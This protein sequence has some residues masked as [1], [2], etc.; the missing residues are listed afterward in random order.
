MNL[1]KKVFVASSLALAFSMNLFGDEVYTIKDKTLKEALEII[2]KKSNLSYIANDKL[3]ETRKINNIENIEGTQKALDKLLQGTGLKAIIKNEAIVI[4]KSEA[5]NSSKNGNDLGKIDVVA[6]SE[7]TEGTG[8]YTLGSTS[9]ATNLSMSLKETPQSISVI[10]RQRIDDQSLN[11]ITDVLQQMPGISVQSIGNGRSTIYSRGGYAITNYQLDGIPTYTNSR[12]QNASQGLADMAVYDHIE[13][14]RGATGLMTGAGDPSGTINMIRK[15]PTKDTQASME[16]TVGSWDL[17]RAQLDISGSLNKNGTIRGRVVSAYQ[18]NESKKDYFEEEKKIFYGVVEADITDTTLLSVGVDYQEYKPTGSSSTG[19]PLFY[20]DGSQTNFSRSLNPGAKWSYDN[21]ETYNIFATLQQELINDWRLKVSTNYLHTDREFY[22]AT[23]A[24]GLLDKNTGDGIALYGGA[25]DAE[26]TQKGFDINIDGTYKL[27][28]RE[29]ELVLGY[30]YFKYDNTHSPLSGTNVEGNPINYYNWGNNPSKPDTKNGKLYDWDHVIIQ[31][32]TYLATRFHPSDDLSLILGGRFSDYEYDDKWDYPV[33]S[34]SNSKENYDETAFTP[35]AGI[36][37]DINEEHSIYISY[38]SVF[39]PQNSKDKNGSTLDPREGNNYEIGYK[40][41]LFGGALNSSIAVYRIEQDNLAV[42][43]T[44]NYI[45]GTTDA[46]YKAIDG[47]VTK[48]LDLEIT[49]EINSNWNLQASYT[50]SKTE[51]QNNERIKTTYPRHMVKLWTTYNLDKLT[52]GGG[53][54]WQSKI[55]FD[56]T[57]WQ[58]PNM[59]FH[60]EQK[61]YAVAN[62]MARYKISKD[63]SATLNINNVFDKKYLSSIEDTFLTGEYGNSRNFIFSLKYT[64]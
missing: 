61:A 1:K 58:Y 10:T 59:K 11:S 31:K 22:G 7:I 42:A 30:S 14:I 9:T 29:H 34:S 24:W 52:L 38:T 33:Y 60:A 37:Y 46:A 36:V 64:F 17:Y 2:S 23:A 27:F 56:T 55:Y 5:K 57:S 48:G 4:V 47:A 19:F 62:A 32:G 53:V 35:Y 43:D 49:G 63:L 26:Q 8:S 40:N 12:T 51:D 54:N 13:V 6:N 21:K 44:G 28:N 16:V 20:S 18:E 25:G 41:E 45:P 50:Y 15:K 39:E 3:L